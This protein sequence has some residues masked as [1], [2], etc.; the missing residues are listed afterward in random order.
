MAQKIYPSGD[1][2]WVELSIPIDMSY[3]FTNAKANIGT[4]LNNVAL[5]NSIFGSVQD[6]RSK[7]NPD[8]FDDINIPK[9]STQLNDIELF[10][11]KTSDEESESTALR[12][13]PYKEAQEYNL[14]SNMVMIDIDLGEGITNV[15]DFINSFFTFS[16]EE[17]VH[18]YVPVFL[19]QEN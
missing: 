9:D 15:D 3:D 17:I 16:E 14:G 1:D 18:T 12:G 19:V 2:A 10:K 4:A 7:A 13:F 8:K 5:A 6:Y 11:W